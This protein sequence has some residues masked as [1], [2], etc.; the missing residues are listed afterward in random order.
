MHVFLISPVSFFN[1]HSTT[2]TLT[3]R[4][5]T[6]PYKYTHAIRTPMS[7]F[8]GLSTADMEI[9]EVATGASS[10]TGTTLTT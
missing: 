4:T 3:T 5:H 8:E 9:L 2:Q 7:T 6:H 10:A 1:S